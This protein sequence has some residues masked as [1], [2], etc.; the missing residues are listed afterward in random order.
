MRQRIFLA[1]SFEE[2]IKEKLAKAIKEV[3]QTLPKN[4]KINWVKK[5]NLH[6]TLLFLGSLENKSLDRLYQIAEKTTKDFPPFWLTS[7]KIAFGPKKRFPPRLVWLEM[8][9]NQQ[10]PKL[11]TKLRN[12][13]TEASISKRKEKQKFLPHITLGRIRNKPPAKK[14]EKKFVVKIRV[15]AIDVI[16]SQ[17]TKKGCKYTVL[18]SILL[19]LTQDEDR[20]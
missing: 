7:Q 3:A 2:E 17:P 18:S 12:D 1:I 10:L 13:I 15:K 4:A 16:A 9:K 14:L 6:L 11:V 20:H 5:K 8:K 19:K